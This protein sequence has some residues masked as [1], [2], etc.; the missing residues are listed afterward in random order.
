LAEYRAARPEE[1]RNR[2]GAYLD[3]CVALAERKPREAIAALRPVADGKVVCL[4]CGFW[5]LGRAYEQVGQPDSALAAY[6]QVAN[7]PRL[8][9]E[10]TYHLQWALAPSLRRLG[11]LYE[12]KGDRANAVVYYS[13][14]VDLWKDADPPLQPAVRD[15][16]ARLARLVGEGH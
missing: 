8:Q 11:E 10:L 14:F 13:R 16:K 4:A 12:A 2:W 5:E 15:A 9:D 1:V 3:G 6:E 7:D